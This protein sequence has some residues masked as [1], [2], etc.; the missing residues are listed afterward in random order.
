MRSRRSDE[1]RADEKFAQAESALEIA[2]RFGE[3]ASITA[4]LRTESAAITWDSG[5]TA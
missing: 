2:R 1:S 4:E 3:R 5:I